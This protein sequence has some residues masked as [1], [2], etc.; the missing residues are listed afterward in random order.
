MTDPCQAPVESC[1]GKGIA[2]LLRPWRDL[3][4]NKGQDLCDRI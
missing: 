4:Q 3:Q 1:V 2:A